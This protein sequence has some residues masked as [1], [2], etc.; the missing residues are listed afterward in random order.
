MRDK[1]PSKR[2][3]EHTKEGDELATIIVEIGDGKEEIIIM[4]YG[5]K[6]EDL[7]ESLAIK[8]SLPKEVKEKLKVDL[9]KSLE[10][11]LNE[12]Q[13]KKS[14]KRNFSQHFSTTKNFEDKSNKEYVIQDKCDTYMNCLK[15]NDDLNTRIQES[16]EALSEKSKIKSNR[17]TPL[18][19]H[20]KK[21][22]D[23]AVQRL[24]KNELKRKEA[25]EKQ[26][27]EIRKEREMKYKEYSYKPMI[28]TYS[29]KLLE[30]TNTYI[31]PENRLPSTETQPKEFQEAECTFKPKIDKHSAEL[32]NKNYKFNDKFS[33]LFEDAK[34][35]QYYKDHLHEKA[36]Y[37]NYSFHPDILMSQSKVSSS[38]KK[39]LHK[40]H[41]R[42]ATQFCGA[43]TERAKRN[44]TNK[45]FRSHSNQKE[46]AKGI[47]KMNEVNKNG[48]NKTLKK[49]LEYIFGVLDPNRTGAILMSSS[50]LESNCLANIRIT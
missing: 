29:K 35:R 34:R 40:T 46:V 24:Y 21:N 44:K 28:N 8:Y 7:A 17:N 10:K 20:L 36:V 27:E 9:K 15:T 43:K 12:V 23:D 47:L 50:S 13:V 49:R 42:S 14:Y 31:R 11:V 26:N 3:D 25:R 32:A 18:I 45:H 5:E 41:A 16:V 37:K 6:P 39:S 33:S 22:V 38:S 1:T 48:F 30:S 2:I 19:K 4:H